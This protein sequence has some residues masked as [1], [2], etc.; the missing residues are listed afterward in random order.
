[1]NLLLKH[2]ITHFNKITQRIKEGIDRVRKTLIG[3]AT[4]D[5]GTLELCESLVEGIVPCSWQKNRINNNQSIHAWVEEHDSRTQFLKDWIEIEEPT[6]FYFGNFYNVHE[7]ISLTIQRHSRKHH[8]SIGDISFEVKV[9]KG[10]KPSSL[11]KPEEGIY[12]SGVRLYGASWNPIDEVLVQQ[13]PKQVISDLPILH[14][15]PRESSKISSENSFMCPVY[16]RG[17]RKGVY[18]TTGAHTNFLFYANLPSNVDQKVW[19]KAG[20]ALFLSW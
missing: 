17:D 4:M 3:E 20:T 1:M 10:V 14:L 8:L 5:K 18:S 9:M 15:I 13:L 12:L 6:V 2:E 16:K 7:L 19:I 11:K